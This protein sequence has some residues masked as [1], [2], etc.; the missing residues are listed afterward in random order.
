M[1]EENKELRHNTSHVDELNRRLALQHRAKEER[2]EHLSALLFN[3]VDVDIAI[4]LHEPIPL[5]RSYPGPYPVTP[6]ASTRL[7]A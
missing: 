3:R 4:L 5:E 7:S 1:G 6:A 2:A